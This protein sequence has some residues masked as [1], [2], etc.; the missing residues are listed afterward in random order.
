MRPWRAAAWVAGWW[1]LTTIGSSAALGAERT[2]PFGHGERLIYELSWYNLV[3]GTATLLVQEDEHGGAPT[4]RLISLAKSNAFVSLFFPVEDRVE[5]VMDQAGLYSLRLDVRQR[6]GKRRRERLTE[7]DQ[8]NNRATVI[9]NGRREV[10]DIPPAVQD[11]LS[12]LYYFRTLPP[13]KVGQRVTIDV[14]ES[15]KN[16]RLAIDGLNRETVRTPLGE[17]ETIRTQAKVE[18]EGIFLDRGDVFIWF[19]D[20]ERRIP[21]HMESKIKIGKIKATL[22]DYNPGRPAAPL[23]ARQ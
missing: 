12:C 3:G 20:D 15:N 2:I 10:F 13:I 4:F 6:E 18:F 17:F 19:T 7:F 8:V 21:I 9:K 22:I 1:L 11:S 16:W 14:H 5:S 23:T